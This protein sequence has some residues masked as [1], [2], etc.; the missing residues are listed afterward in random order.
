MTSP[1]PPLDA[2]FLATQKARLLTLRL[3]LLRTLDV[4]RESVREVG[5]AADHQANEAEDRA[6]DQSLNE[7]GRRVSD[8]LA[9]ARL[10]ID[11]ALAKLDDGTYGFSD[12]SGAPIPLVRLQAYPQAQL[13]LAEEA[14][15]ETDTRQLAGDRD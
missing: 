10:A 7:V 9:L 12:L 11:R 8:H 15:R 6:Q 1:V 2:E 3:E 4:E 14:A 5:S 13:T